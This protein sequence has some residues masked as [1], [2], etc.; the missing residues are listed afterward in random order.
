MAAGESPCPTTGANKMLF[1]S[2]DRAAVI[3]IAPGLL[4]WRLRAEQLG[5]VVLD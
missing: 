5:D 4:P 3:A 2:K 1:S